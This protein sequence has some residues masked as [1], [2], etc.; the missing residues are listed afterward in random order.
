M[1]FKNLSII[2]GGPNCVYAIEILLKNILSIRDKK[3]RHIRIFEKSG[4]IGSGKTH[5]VNLSKN[6]L[7][8]RVAGQISLG[9]Y[10]FL[11]FPKSLSKF[12]YNFMEWKNKQVGKK[13]NN[14]K[15]K[16]WPSRFIFG[17][18]LK[19]K[20]LDLLEIYSSH[21]NIT[22]EIYFDEVVAINT[23]KKIEIITKENKKFESDKVLIA[24]GNY[25]SSDTSTKLNKEIKALTKKTD[26]TFEYNFIENLDKKNYWEK[27]SKNSI[28]IFGTGVSS[29]DIISMLSKRKN[30]IFPISR[31][32]LFPFA[33]PLNQK[34][35]NPKKLEHSGILFSKNFV[36]EINLIITKNKKNKK[37]NYKYILLP[38]IKSEF[39]L[40]YFK[41][42][43]SK[44]DFSCFKLFVKSKLSLKNKK[45][46]NLIDESH[47]ID[48]Y[49]RNFLINKNLKKNFY[50]KN[51]FS[52]KKILDE[53][54]CEKIS[55]FEIFTNPLM[56]HKKNFTQEYL[57]FLDWDIQE[58]KKGNLSSPFKK[59]CDGLWR[60]LRPFFTI[61]FDDCKNKKIY[62]EFIT[63]ILPI[64]NR[65]ADGPSL[66]IMK[67]IKKLILNRVI[68]FKYK[69]KYK[70]KKIDNKLYLSNDNYSNKIDY[71]F[72]AIANIYKEQFNG[73][74]LMLSMFRNNLISLKKNNFSNR[75][76]LNLNKFQ[77]PIN[78]KNIIN[79]N[80]TF[81]GPASEGSKFF[82][83][84][85]S[86]PDKKQF[87]IIDLEK[88]VSK[89]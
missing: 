82:H 19:Q 23:K 24:T 58:A 20:M 72:S 40:I 73:D 85:L 78:K 66:E 4:L 17:L 28:V 61:L 32:F 8:N 5:S 42:Y 63:Y 27:F 21:T 79:K 35:K 7:L 41:N 74:N 62:D 11:K 87:N 60:D 77:N 83:H 81:V 57:K 9:S 3:K 13:I 30:K 71:I 22:I 33:R 2:G 1:K 51:W 68:N 25:L 48:G 16:D 6:I 29:L 38:F 14:L 36:K 88:W 75:Q 15:S 10:P 39:Y 84:T 12:D 54:I 89:L 86:R 76:F 49:L 55:F 47:E 69:D 37:F 44:K 26:A 34:L 43:L 59:A 53:I 18:S 80:I 52:Q 56:L 67:K 31:T 50:I 65:L 46:F 45:I 64:H 70:F